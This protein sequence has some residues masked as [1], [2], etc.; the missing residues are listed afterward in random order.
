MKRL[1]HLKLA[2]LTEF[3]PVAVTFVEK[4]AEAFGL[5]KTE[6]LQLTLATEEIFLYLCKYICPGASVNIQC[7][8]GIYYTKVDFQFPVSEFNLS[9]LNV[10]TTI[11]L[12]AETNLEEIGLLIATRFVDRFMIA[13]GRHDEVNLAIIKEKVYPEG[14]AGKIGEVHAIKNFTVEAPDAESLK[15]FALMAEKHKDGV[16]R[17]AFLKYPGKVVDMVSSG[18]YHAFTAI[19]EKGEISGGILY[20]HRNEKIVEC[21]GPFVFSGERADEIASALLEKC[22]A[23]IARTK[24]IGIVN[25][26]DMP[27]ALQYTFEVLGVLKFYQEGKDPLHMPAFY[28]LLHEDPGNPVWTHESLADYLKEE[29]QRLFL[30]REIRVVSDLGE[31]HAGSSIFSTE[32]QREN[33]RV[34]IRP[35]WPGSDIEQN[36]ENHIHGLKHE[37]IRNLFFELDLGIS[38][39]AG[40]IPIIMTKGF[41]PGIVIPFAGH[42]DL[43]IFQYHE[44]KS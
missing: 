8:N 31:Q 22:M 42:S 1:L 12:D 14:A 23:R 43:I 33:S 18:E 39:H 11:S 32:F 4:T 37:H 29:Y 35:M 7:H 28:R 16:L 26:H 41:Q 13:K 40:I 20:F 38:W 17:P 5:G 10:T 44:T 36:V 24:A 3:L 9:S 21:L 6:F 19:N 27:E 15:L 34:T 30:A 25:L 2:A